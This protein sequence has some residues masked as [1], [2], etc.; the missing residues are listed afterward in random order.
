VTKVKVLIVEDEAAIAEL[1]Q[2]HVQ[3]EGLSARVVHSGRVALDVVRDEPPDLV[4]LD[5]MLP[6][7]DGL[8]VCRR[9]KHKAETRA[10]PILMVSAKGEEADIVAGIE[11]GAED[12]VTK[13][14]SPKVLLARMK[15]ILRR[16]AADGELE[17][18]ADGRLALAGGTL[19]IDPERHVVTIEGKPV[20]LTLTEFGLLHYLA[21]RPGFVR[22]RDQIIAA[23]HGKST[24]LSS[25]T[26]D[27]H[28]TA[29]RRKLG[30]LSH[31][32][33]TVRG[34]GYRLTDAAN[35]D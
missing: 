5:L 8:E 9:L 22:T 3:R 31:V 15:N 21:S 4:V 28:V 27:V 20:E 12:Y 35:E 29:L 6:D 7:L 19:V 30:D 33:E 14:F 17:V 16:H 10:I 23:V 32:I 11:L 34:V 24:V 13:P 26:V 2:F 1:I 18:T 25:R